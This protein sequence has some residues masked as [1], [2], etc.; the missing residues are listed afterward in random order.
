MLYANGES[1][2]STS[3]TERRKEGRKKGREEKK[4]KLDIRSSNLGVFTHWP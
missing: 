1:V 4:R 2:N 3:E